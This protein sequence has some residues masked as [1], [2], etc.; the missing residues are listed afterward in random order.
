MPPGESG[1][2]SIADTTFASLFF[3]VLQENLEYLKKTGAASIL[4]L[5]PLFCMRFSYGL[6]KG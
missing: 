5:L 4:E 6:S 1:I 3:K 2:F